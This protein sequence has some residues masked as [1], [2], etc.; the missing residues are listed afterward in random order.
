VTLVFIHGAGCLPHVFNEQLAAFP[1]AIAVNLPGHGRPGQPSTIAE[2][3]EAVAGELHSRE[4]ERAVLAGSSMGGAI[5]LELALRHDPRVA[6][7]I[8]LGSSA[9]LR[10]APAIF[11]SIDADFPGAAAALAEG[12]FAYPSR[13][14]V[15]AAVEMMLAVGRQQT[16]RD[17]SACDAFDVRERL[18]EIDVPLLALTGEKDVMT[19]P[20]FAEAFVGRVPAAEARILPD[21]GHLAFVERPEATNDAIRTF[22]TSLA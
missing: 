10:V 13:E 21:A 15:A 6:A 12:F 2:F 3:A 14:R 17:F 22:V 7:L 20:K 16:R 19:P 18:G 4:I 5:A 8:M 9:R 1:E 11:E